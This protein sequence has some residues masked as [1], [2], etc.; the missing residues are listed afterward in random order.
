MVIL[1]ATVMHMI[2]VITITPT[3][4]AR[5]TVMGML[6][7][8]ATAITATAMRRPVSAWPLPSA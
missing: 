6:T 7:G 8:I 5:A 3:D 2:T 4:M 1:M